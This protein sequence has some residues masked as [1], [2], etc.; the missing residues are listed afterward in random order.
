MPEENTNIDTALTLLCQEEAKLA[1]YY[2]R[3][4]WSPTYVAAMHNAIDG[5]AGICS[6]TPKQLEEAFVE[7]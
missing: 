5:I 3:E 2:P 1:E 4:S 6:I 7:M